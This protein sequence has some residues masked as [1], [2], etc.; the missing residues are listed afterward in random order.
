MR[1][2]F[3]LIEFGREADGRVLAEFYVAGKSQRVFAR[4]FCPARAAGE[5]QRARP[6]TI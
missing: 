5:G 4:L 2:E 3:R 1:S 6:V